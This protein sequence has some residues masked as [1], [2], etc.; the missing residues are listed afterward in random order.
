MHIARHLILVSCI[1]TGLV[2][3]ETRNDYRNLADFP[4]TELTPLVTERIWPAE[5]GQA[6]V[7]LWKDDKTLA[8]SITID[9]NTRPDHA[10][11][12]E[13]GRKYGF[14]FTWF[15][16]VGG[17][18]NSINPGFSGNWADFQALLAA[19]HDVQ[20]HSMTHR[21]KE[22]NL[23]AEDDYVQAIPPLTE[24]LKGTRPLTLAYPGG[25][26]PNDPVAA[27]RHHIGARGTIGT[28]N[29]PRPNWF[30]VHSVGDGALVNVPIG[31]KGDWAS[32]LPLLNPKARNYRGWYCTHF[33]GVAWN[34]DIQKTIMPAVITM[35]DTIK[36][37]ESEIWVA[38]F[39]EAALY[40][41]ERDTAKLQV[42]NSTATA[43]TLLLTDRMYDDWYDFPLTIRLRV[44][45][46]W[47]AVA[48]TQGGKPLRA[49]VVEHNG[50]RFAMV[51]VV[52]DRGEATIRPQAK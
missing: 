29:G 7:C 46:A 22:A 48:A 51:D 43:I 45:D 9:D 25:G 42:T 49:S 28:T 18:V 24:N 11:W 23:S 37:H 41:Q 26:L 31:G 5:V 10:W 12:L 8:F 20:S 36:A 52:P 19:G 44:P 2:A 6:V 39:R 21:S 13:Q 15:A 34:P 17:L 33:H 32:M 16:I 40:G 1:C 38:L 30:D 14:R 27:A 50:H 47:T 3:G 4:N 35:L